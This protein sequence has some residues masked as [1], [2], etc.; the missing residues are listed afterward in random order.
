MLFGIPWFGIIAIVA[1]AG[2]LIYAYKE[3]ELEVEEKIQVKAR[4]VRELEKV[5]HNLKSRV[6]AMEERLDRE[7]SDKKK[8]S[9]RS[10]I[11]INNELEDQNS[12]T[13]SSQT[14]NRARS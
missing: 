3:K 4:E 6:D 13:N 7:A 1:I 2:G 10:E 5:V 14:P 12:D 11:E 9:L 8:E